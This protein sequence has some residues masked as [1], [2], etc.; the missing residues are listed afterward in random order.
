VWFNYFCFT[1]FNWFSRRLAKAGLKVVVHL[2]CNNYIIRISYKS[3]GLVSVPRN[4][5]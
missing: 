4:W 1:P 2:L 3:V 5:I